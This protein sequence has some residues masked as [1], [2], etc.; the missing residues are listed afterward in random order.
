MYRASADNADKWSYIHGR[1]ER[2]PG[3]LQPRP[4]FTIT[5]WNIVSDQENFPA[6]EYD[7]F[8]WAGLEELPG[9]SPVRWNW[10]LGAVLERLI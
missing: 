7:P 8:D 10:G 5:E 3:I 2:K 6:D 9:C 1:A 4:F